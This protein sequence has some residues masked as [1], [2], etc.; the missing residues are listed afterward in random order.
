MA[1]HN[2]NIESKI[3]PNV[4]MDRNSFMPVHK[5]DIVLCILSDAQHDGR[6][7]SE[8][9]VGGEERLLVDEIMQELRPIVE[10]L[11]EKAK[12]FAIHGPI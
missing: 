11:V 7:W 5:A 1:T 4:H 9:F 3:D 8:A 12:P 2:Y 6:L 10:S